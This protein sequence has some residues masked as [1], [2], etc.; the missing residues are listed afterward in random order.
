MK[1][2]FYVI[3]LAAAVVM[4]IVAVLTDIS[5]YYL[6]YPLM[7]IALGASGLAVLLPLFS[8]PAAGGSGQI[9]G[10]LLSLVC[11]IGITLVWIYDL[12]PVIRSK[13]H[14]TPVPAGT[15]VTRTPTLIPTS[16]STSPWMIST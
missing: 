3:P 1:Y 8:L 7:G 10:A 14:R 11:M 15:I 6:K 2:D 12:M 5:P 16:T 4:A 13:P 9:R